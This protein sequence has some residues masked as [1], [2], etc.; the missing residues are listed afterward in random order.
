MKLKLN[1]SEANAKGVTKPAIKTDIL[2]I[3]ITVGT[4]VVNIAEGL[5]NS[6][7][8]TVISDGGR[9]AIVPQD[10]DQIILEFGD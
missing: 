5:D 8:V 1:P 4:A 9:L 3:D 7:L 2:D 10:N 6:L